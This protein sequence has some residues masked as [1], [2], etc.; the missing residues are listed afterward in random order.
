MTKL[1][2]NHAIRKEASCCRTP[3]WHHHGRFRRKSD[4][5]M[6]QRYKCYSCG[7]TVSNA[8]FDDACWQKKRHLNYACMMMLSSLVSMRRIG[9][10]LNI[11]PK[12]VARK[13]AYLG[14]TLQKKMEAQDFSHVSHIQ[15]DELQTIEHTKLKP[16]SV[17]MAVSTKDRRIIGFRVASMP[18]TGL[19][20]KVSRKKYGLR[21]DHRRRE[22]AALCQDIKPQLPRLHTI[23]SD[24]CSFYN[25]ILSRVFPAAKHQQF[26]GKKSSV[27]GQGELKKVVHDPLFCIN[28]T[29]AMLRANINRFIR[30]TWCT[31]KKI[32]PLIH[33][34]TVYMFVH[35]HI[36]LKGAL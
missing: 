26:K 16:L 1:S 22:F 30:K 13:L 34:L 8:T 32:Q 10:V 29:F 35:N 28:H 3:C 6:I 11:N 4:S 5:R 24:E 17:A 23:E 36:I 14:E 15:C 25:P 33:H 12:T 2:I 27:A 19:L 20:A 31:T 7:K 9:R 21:P 18:A